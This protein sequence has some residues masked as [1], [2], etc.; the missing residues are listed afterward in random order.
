MPV[1]DVHM[2]PMQVAEL[3][4]TAVVQAAQK[5]AADKHSQ[6]A[7]KTKLPPANRLRQERQRPA[8]KRYDF[9]P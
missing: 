1:S 4:C 6:C 8:W 7:G 2:L 5:L 3:S 9:L